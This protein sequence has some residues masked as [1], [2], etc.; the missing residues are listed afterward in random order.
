VMLSQV[1]MSGD[2]TNSRPPFVD[3]VPD[4]LDCF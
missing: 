4:A 1:T 3:S 2:S